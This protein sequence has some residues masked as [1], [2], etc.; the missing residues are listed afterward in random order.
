[1]SFSVRIIDSDKQVLI[2]DNIF[3]GL[4]SPKSKVTTVDYDLFPRKLQ[5]P[6]TWIM[7]LTEAWVNFDYDH[8]YFTGLDLKEIDGNAMNFG[9]ISQVEALLDVKLVS[10]PALDQI[11][12]GVFIRLLVTD[13]QRA[14]EEFQK[15]G[16]ITPDGMVIYLPLAS[17]EE[18][19]IA[20]KV[21]EYYG[22]NIYIPMTQSFATAYGSHVVLSSIGN[23]DLAQST[24]ISSGG[25]EVTILT[26]H[27]CGDE[28]MKAFGAW[29]EQGV[30]YL[31]ELKTPNSV[32]TEPIEMILPYIKDLER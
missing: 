10:S 3:M 17:V 4:L 16:F 2:H 31:L 29:E 15:T 32:T 11:V 13:S 7:N 27:L 19:G 22:L 1:V 26:N 8:Q 28:A 12:K 25:I 20:P 21:V 5:I 30:G 9:S 18:Q 24:H 6:Q 23:Q 14:T